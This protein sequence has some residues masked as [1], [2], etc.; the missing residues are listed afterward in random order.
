MEDNYIDRFYTDA[1]EINKDEEDCWLVDQIEINAQK[2]EYTLC[3]YVDSAV[4][5]GE[6]EN[7]EEIISHYVS[8]PVF[9]MLLES[10]KKNGYKLTSFF[11]GQSDN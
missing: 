9:D 10:V 2:K 1:K 11:T 4:A 7:G 6:D 5:D 3:E 8:R